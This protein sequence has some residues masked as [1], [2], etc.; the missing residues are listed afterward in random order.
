MKL[1]TVLPAV[2][3]AL[4]L[5]A[6][7]APPGPAGLVL[8]V[9]PE[10]RADGNGSR[11]RPYSSLEQ[12][13]DRIRELRQGRGFPPGG[14]TVRVHGG[15]YAVTN[16]FLLGRAD[17]GF[18]GGPITWQAA[19]GEPPVFSGGV[20]LR[21]FTP[22]ADAA[23]RD[24]LPESVRSRVVQ[25]DLAAL[26]VIHLPPLELGGFGSGRGFF[27][28]PVPELFFN[29]RALPRAGWPDTG[30]THVAAVP[31]NGPA[32]LEH[33]LRSSRAGRF[34]VA[35]PAR[36]AR[37]AAEPELWLYGYWF[38]DWADSYE[39]VAQVDVAAGAL[40]LAPPLHTYGFRARQ[41][42][43][44]VNALCE[45]DQPGE[46]YLD[47]A[48][49]LL[50][51]YPPSDPAQAVVELSLFRGPL[52]KFEQLADVTLSGLVWELGA[53]D[54]VQLSDARHVTLDSCTVRRCGGDGIV[55]AGGASNT[56]RGCVVHSLGRGA[57]KVEGGDR[58]TLAPGGH[59]VEDC[60]LHD[61]SRVDRTYTPGAWLGGVGHVFAHNEVHD[62]PSSAL[63][64]GGNDHL[65][66]GNHIHHVVTESDDQGAV[67]MWGDPTYRGNQF[68]DNYFHDVGSAWNGGTEVKLGQAGI[69]LDDAISG[70]RIAGN[71]FE[72]CG[73]G[74]AGFG[75]VQI[76][77][78]KDNLVESNLFIRCASAV[79]F[80]A[81]GAARWTNFVAGR[82]A[83]PDVGAALY[84][85]RYPELGNLLADV[86]RNEVRG[87]VVYGDTLFRRPPPALVQ[88]DNQLL[89]NGTPPAVWAK[90][91]GA[92]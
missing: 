55:V 90:A 21:R 87:N 45:L 39:K 11:I 86:N 41:P 49:R 7:R 46:W 68:L 44:A 89:T 42:F 6:C 31:T 50:V 70:V 10:G 26:G 88:A 34:T 23:L 22:L 53:G 28:H 82:L 4:A 72:R 2:L 80:S 27:T 25:C 60:V 65:V 9:A 15:R 20:R 3:C 24:R 1:R 30:F 36:L 33:G 56:L 29:G 59:R 79:S 73:G 74:G 8:H 54:G 92:R 14:I 62:V 75:A 37:W 76:H 13:R 61:L 77:G 57:L 16:T 38:W 48:R 47:A 17:A 66:A 64:V 83:K 67:D 63:R 5:S 18:A 81:W 35:E 40:T 91:Y 51:L 71:R 19:R 69:R 52:A 85:A 43:R 58:R 78:G 32:S 12:A 84:R